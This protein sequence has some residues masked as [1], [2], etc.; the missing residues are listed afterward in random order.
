[1]KLLRNLRYFMGKRSDFIRRE[2]DFYPTPYTPYKPIVSLLPHLKD[3]TRYIE[4]CW[5]NGSCKSSKQTQSY[6][7]VFF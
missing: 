4:P 7:C 1:M 2:K 6:L 5:S 3:S